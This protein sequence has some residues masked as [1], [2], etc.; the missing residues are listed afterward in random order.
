MTADSAALVDVIRRIVAE[1]M[2]RLYTA[3]LA[4][5]QAVHPHSGAGDDDTYSATVMLHDSELVLTRVP[6]ATSRVG[7]ASIPPVGGLVLVQ[8]VGG[9]VNRPVITGGLYNDEDR[10]PVNAEGQWLCHLPLGAG[11][12]EGVRVAASSADT[13]ALEVQIGGALAM[14][15]KDDD[16]VVS[17]D[18]GGGAA[19]LTIDSDGTVRLTS[20][21]DLAVEAGTNLTLKG[22]NVKVE[23]AA[24]VTVKG[25]VINLN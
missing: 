5:V 8:F 14:T 7:V 1:E 22:Q 12:G 13:P 20:G 19:E 10:P 25:G 23:G 24:E 2:R 3:S 16:P 17:L 18:V 15:L 4:V 9:D 6:V 21:R 11:D